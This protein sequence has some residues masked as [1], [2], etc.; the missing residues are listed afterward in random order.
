MNEALLAVHRSACSVLAARLLVTTALTMAIGSVAANAA[1]LTSEQRALVAKYNISEADQVKLFGAV[2]VA[3]APGSS[4]AGAQSHAD[5]SGAA[6]GATGLLAGT[7]VW[8]GADTYKSLGDRLTNINGGT[9]SLTGSFGGVAGVNS[10]FTLGDS[11]F[12][13]QA[14]ASYGIYD[15]KGRLRIVPD[16]TNPEEQ[17]YYTAGVYKRGNL[18]SPD[19]SI[20]DRI[21]FGVVYDGMVAKRWGINANDIELA[22]VRASIGYALTNSTEVGVWGATGVNHDMAAVTVAGAPGLLTRIQAATHANAYLKHN[23][24]FGGELTGYVGMFDGDD[25]GKWQVGA[26]GKVPL[27]DYLSMSA[28]ANYVV[29]D[30]PDGPVGSGREQFDASVGIAY[31]FGGNAA[32]STVAGNRRLPLLDVGSNRTFLV[33]D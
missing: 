31:H 17:L 28:S 10:G 4:E 33:T 30:A 29:P 12:G 22:Q 16:A 20:V 18:S 13:F 8:V 23:F 2:E 6:E 25:I 26:A 1:N 32:S 15:W 27:N 19:P 21:N 14:G 7:Y 9:G 11:D 5:P 24:D 3:E